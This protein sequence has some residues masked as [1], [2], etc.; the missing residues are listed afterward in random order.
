MTMITDFTED[1]KVPEDI[2]SLTNGLVLILFTNMPEGSK[3]SG[4]M[5]SFNTG[6]D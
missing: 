1:S 5:L 4:D 6:P 2:V 3:V